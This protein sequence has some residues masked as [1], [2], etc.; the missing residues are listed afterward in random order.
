MGTQFTDEQKLA[1]QTT[2]KSVLVS[3]AAGSGK[4]TA[5]VDGLSEIKGDGVFRIVVEIC[6]G[7]IPCFVGC[8]VSFSV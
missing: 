2:D 6:L 1:I 3:A 5:L 7:S 4:T 8:A